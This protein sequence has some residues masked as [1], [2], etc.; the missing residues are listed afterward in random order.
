[1]IKE[2]VQKKQWVY[3]ESLKEAE[4]VVIFQKLEL[5]SSSLLKPKS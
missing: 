5:F 1:M 2:N 4:S 3:K